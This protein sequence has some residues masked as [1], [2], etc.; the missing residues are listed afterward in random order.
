MSWFVT[1]V[2]VHITIVGISL[3]LPA[4]VI[5]CNA[6]VEKT[7]LNVNRILEDAS[8]TM[9]SLQCNPIAI[10]M[11]TSDDCHKISGAQTFSV[12]KQNLE[13]MI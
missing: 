1:E 9:A 11:V 6:D 12:F 13:L 5:C 10:F 4:F 8:I 3:T 2:K 7:P